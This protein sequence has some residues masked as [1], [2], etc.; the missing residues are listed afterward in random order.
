M[1]QLYTSSRLRVLR[2]CLRKHYYRYGLGVTTPSSDH[3]R[4]GTVAHAAIEAWLVSWRDDSIDNRLLRAID[5]IEACDLDE[6]DR[7]RLRALIAAYHTR[8]SAEDW[9]IVAVEAEFRYE[10]GGHEIGGKIDAIIRDADGKAWVVEHK[11]TGQDASAGSAY[12]EKLAIDSQLSI[13]VDGATMLGHDIAGVV[14]DVLQRPRHEPRLA[15]PPDKREYTQGKK[16]KL[17]RGVGSVSDTVGKCAAC[18]STGWREAPRLYAT[19]RDADESMVDFES[20]LVE[21]I[22]SSPDDYLIRGVVVRLADELPRMRVDLVEAIEIEATATTRGVW[23]RNPDACARFGA[24]CPYF[25]ACSGRADIND[26][27]LFP[28]GEVHPELARPKEAA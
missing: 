2:E 6:V 15:T 11:T 28:R 20:R 23:P 9:E 18:N 17:C 8:W 27:V 1:S 14:Y 10:L 3:S 5:A 7:V 22:C 24:L 21:E 25:A 26:P 12:W 13:Y 19:Q 4:F 16:C